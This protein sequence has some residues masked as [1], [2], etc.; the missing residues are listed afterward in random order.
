MNLLPLLLLVCELGN[1]VDYM[2]RNQGAM[3][4]LK[5]MDLLDEVAGLG[6]VDWKKVP[7][8]L[9]ALGDVERAQ[10]L[11]AMKAKFDIPDDEVEAKIEKGLSLVV[12]VAA[13]VEEASAY[14]KELKA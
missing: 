11:E 8:E 1:V 6:N 7:A 13:V 9:K 12:K 2:G 5:L 4:Y 14:V 10:M 3:K